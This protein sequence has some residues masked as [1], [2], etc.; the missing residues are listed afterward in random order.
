[1][2]VE[3]VG[4]A[5]GLPIAIAAALLFLAWKQ[6]A[7]NRDKPDALLMLTTRLDGIESGVKAVSEQVKVT[8]G[9]VTKVDSEIA[10]VRER[11]A[12]IE[13]KLDL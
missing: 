10:N 1:M 2:I 3:Y 9:K 5:F 7:I 13:G 6:G 8:D 12:R 11:V 4:K